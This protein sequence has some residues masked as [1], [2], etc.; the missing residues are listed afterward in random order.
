MDRDNIDTR[1][2]REAVEALRFLLA[3][4]LGI[5]GVIC[6]WIGY[7]CYRLSLQ[8]SPVHDPDV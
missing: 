2:G 6:A 7:H 8:I 1:I 4:P 3:A 5:V